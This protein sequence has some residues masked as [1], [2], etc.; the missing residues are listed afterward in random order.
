M[1]IQLSCRTK[2][3]CGTQCMTSGD[4]NAFRFESNVCTSL[5]SVGLYINSGD[6]SPV[7]VYMT[8]S[9]AGKIH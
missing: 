8:D 6:A 2:V 4:C 9:D 7:G 5:K 3:E 1:Y